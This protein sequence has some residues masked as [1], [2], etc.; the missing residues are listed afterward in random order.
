MNLPPSDAAARTLP[1]RVDAAADHRRLD[2]FL[3]EALHWRSR[4]QLADMIDRG[5]VRINGEPAKKAR[6]VATSDLVTIE[7]PHVLAPAALAPPPILFADDDLVVV[8]K[9]AGLAVHP[10]STCLHDNL[11]VRLR[12][13]FGESPAIIHRLDRNTT[14][15][16]AFARR[17]E[18]VPFYMAQFEHRTV[19]KQYVAIVHGELA[20]TG[21]IELPLLAQPSARVVVDP[22]GRPART[23]WQ[24][25][26]R[27][28]TA[29]MIRIALHT[30]RKHQI[31]V[32]F[33]ALGHPLAF[34]DVY[35]R[36]HERASWPPT[37]SIALHAARLDLDH[38]ERGRM[39][40]EAPLPE[41]MQL[42]WRE[43]VAG[44]PAAGLP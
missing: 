8:D 31:R 22:R 12:A 20:D 24:V 7:L 13:H 14:G 19:R 35:G 4:R 2:A 15:V 26:E 16:I 38:R 6:R 39:T 42:L 18:R 21:C 28:P 29:T 27:A 11:L 43:L 23:Q 40:F 41:P 36:V 32:H 25:V 33:A 9:P 5:L 10:A 1:L 30:G 44:A 37:R 34:D 3:A 17:A